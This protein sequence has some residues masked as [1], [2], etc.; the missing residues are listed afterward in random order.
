MILKYKQSLPVELDYD[1]SL[2]DAA[3][4]LSDRWNQ[5]R[6]AS[7]KELEST[8]HA[9]DIKNFN[10]NQKVV[11]LEKLQSYPAFIEEVP[12][13][14]AKVY[15]FD[16][17]Q[18]AEIRFRFYILALNCGKTYAKAAAEWVAH[19]GRMKFCRPL[20][21]SLYKVDSSLALKTFKD[22]E[23]FYHPIAAKQI[24]RDLKLD[25]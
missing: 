22:N 11:F 1:T 14:I 9:D 2:A 5:R 23:N 3:F 19:Q 25:K 4:D 10:S 18:N 17:A 16:E 8:F 21:R 20:F 15:G 13:A 6:N 24:R 12:K 7:S